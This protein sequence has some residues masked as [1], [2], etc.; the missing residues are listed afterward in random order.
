MWLKPSLERCPL[1]PYTANKRWAWCGAQHMKNVTT[2]TTVKDKKKY[3]NRYFQFAKIV[4]TEVFNDEIWKWHGTLNFCFVFL[5]KRKD[6]TLKQYTLT[7][8]Q[9]IYCDLKLYFS[10]KIN[11]W[12]TKTS[13]SADDT[14]INIFNSVKRK[15]I[16]K[17]FIT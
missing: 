3:F 2:T 7:L 13:L 12:I 8:L 9:S 14:L 16:I 10:T 6:E 1:L 5:E 11:I 17:E 4:M 15:F